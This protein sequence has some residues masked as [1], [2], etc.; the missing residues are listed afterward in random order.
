ML[1]LVQFRDDPE[2]RHI[3]MEQGPAHLDFLQ[4]N[5]T[6]LKVAGSLRKEPD[7]RALGGIWIVEAQTSTEVR[8]LINHDPFMKSGLRASVEILVFSKAFPDISKPV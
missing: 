8:E 4:A 3:R 7:E 2:K 1:Y 5:A 6:R